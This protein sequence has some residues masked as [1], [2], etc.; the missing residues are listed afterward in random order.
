[1]NVYCILV[2]QKPSI[3][4]PRPGPKVTIED[5]SPIIT[6]VGSQITELA[7][8]KIS[9]TCPTEGVPPPS[10]TWTKDGEQ[11]NSTGHFVIDQSGTLTIRDVV[12][13]DS[14]KYTCL[15]KNKAGVSE[16]TSSLDI[17]GV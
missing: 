16:V 12:V 14:G 15:A 5:G 13:D 11:L 6:P 4:V 8:V 17:L 2:L 1:M 7:Y 10:V 3:T 9:L